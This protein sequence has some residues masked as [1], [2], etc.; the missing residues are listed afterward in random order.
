MKRKLT[1]QELTMYYREA[2]I[3]TSDAN[4]K[5]AN[6]WARKLLKQ[7][8]QLKNTKEGRNAISDL[9]TDSNPHVRCWASSH[10][11]EWNPKTAIRTL[12][13]LSRSEGPCSFDAQIILSEY[14]KGNLSSTP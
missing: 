10:S 12:E 8:N 3:G 5:N 13:E 9:M 7:Y 11:L 14:Q 6:K 1:V 2:A 4:P